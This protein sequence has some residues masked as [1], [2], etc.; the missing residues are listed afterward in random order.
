M[1]MKILLINLCLRP[2][3]IVKYPPV[4][5]GYIATS[6]KNNGYKFQIYDMDINDYSYSDLDEYLHNNSFDIIIMGCIVTGYKIVKEVC[7][8]IK[9]NI[10]QSKIIVGNSVADSIPNILLGKTLADVAI[11]GEGDITI[12]ELMKVF[13]NSLNADLSD[14]KGIVFKS[15]DN[16]ITTEKRIPIPNLDI[17]PFFDY[18]LWDI[19]SYIKFMQ[20][21][22]DDP[23]PMPRNEIRPMP[24]NTARGCPFKCHFCYHVFR[25]Y[26]Y[27]RRSWKVIFDEIEHL[28]SKYNINFIYFHDDL[29]FPNLASVNEFLKEYRSRNLKFYWTATS[30]GNLFKKEEDIDILLELK[31]CGCCSIES[32]LESADQEILKMMNKKLDLDDYRMQLKLLLKAGIARATS[33]VL[34]YPLETP[35]TIHKTFEFCRVNNVYP[36]IGYALPFPGS[37]LYDYVYSHGF[38]PDVEDFLMKLG[39]RQDLRYNLTKMSDEQFQSIVLDEA[40]KTSEYLKLNIDISKLIKSQYRRTNMDNNENNN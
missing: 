2:H 40:E 27:R 34:G 39:D 31:K 35:E 14:V 26:N 10:P 24:V 6:L 36:S 38:I 37:P 32:S 8:I 29:T 17:L 11:I 30:R 13:D 4:G 7:S 1:K 9:K 21:G 19:E 15:G 3:S 20:N 23:T 33:I 12:I 5:L 22:L 18:S 25:D 28:I 16:I